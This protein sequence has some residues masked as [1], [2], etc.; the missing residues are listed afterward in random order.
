MSVFGKNNYICQKFTEMNCNVHKLNLCFLKQET[1]KNPTFKFNTDIS[2][3]SFTYTVKNYNIGQTVIYGIG[4]GISIVDN[5]TIEI[6]IPIDQMVIGS[7]SHELLWENADGIKRVVFQGILKVSETGEYCADCQTDIG[8]F[9]VNIIN[10]EIVVNVILGTGGGGN[11]IN[12]V[13]IVPSW[14]TGYVDVKKSLYFYPNIDTEQKVGSMSVED[15]ILEE[16]NNFIQSRVKQL[17]LTFKN[18]D[19]IAN[20]NPI[21]LIERYRPTKRSRSNNYGESINLEGNRKA[22]FIAPHNR[23]NQIPIT[24]SEILNI[25]F[26]QETYFS[27][28]GESIESD[29]NAIKSRGQKKAPSQ[30]GYQ[31]IQFRIKTDDGIS[32]PILIFKLTASVHQKSEGTNWTI[33]RN[34]TEPQKNYFVNIGYRF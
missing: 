33:W 5:N 28:I 11:S 7:Y 23:T 12:D 2:N 16:N 4:S 25:D 27:P 34:D 20:K 31:I 15:Y 13:E 32:K 8:E 30:S 1:P 6:E 22:Q 9:T 29:F 3:D 21:L 24:S 19:L 10:D 17:N 26:E 18:F 14:Y